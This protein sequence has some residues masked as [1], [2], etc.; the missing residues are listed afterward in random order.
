MDEHFHQSKKLSKEKLIV[1]MQKNNHPALLHFLVMFILF[2]A[3]GVWAVIAWNNTWW[4]LLL[5]QLFF[6][7]M[8][9]STFASLHETAHGTAFKSKSLN[10]IAAILVGIAHI[11]P[12]TAFRELHFMHHRHTHIP[13][14]D[15]EISLG[16]KPAPS[17]IGSLPFYLSWLSGFPLLSFKIFM[18]LMGALGMPNVIRKLYFPFVHEKVRWKL[19]LDSWVVLSVHLIFLYLAIFVNSSLWALFLGQVVGHCILAF[20]LTPEHNGLPH[21]GDILNKTRSFSVNHFVR[22]LMWN[23][24]YHAEH[25][26]YPA[27]PFHALPKLHEEIIGELK[28]KDQKHAEFHFKVLTGKIGRN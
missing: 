28:H 27:V 15:P 5:S 20:Y 2:L 8:C 12:A 23:M 11:Y 17:V 4:E 9:C 13:G 19:A 16:T 7:V 6:G 26:A 25:H 18:L 10:N 22:I 21:D 24:P 1:L 3:A 14:L